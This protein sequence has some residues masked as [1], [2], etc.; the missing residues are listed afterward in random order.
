MKL[1][2]ASESMRTGTAFGLGTLHALGFRRSPIGEF[3]DVDYGVDV[4][5]EAFTA[6]GSM[7]SSR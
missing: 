1:A 6:Y 5:P 2:V 4:S 3:Q 7:P